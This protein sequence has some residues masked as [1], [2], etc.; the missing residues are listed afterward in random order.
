MD[1]SEEQEISSSTE[2]IPIRT[3]RVCGKAL[4]R[5]KKYTF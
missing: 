4:P 1:D 5:V 3:Y 2:E